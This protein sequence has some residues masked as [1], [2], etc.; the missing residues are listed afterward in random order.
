MECLEQKYSLQNCLSKIQYIF[1]VLFILCIPFQDC[2]LQGTFLRYFGMNLSNIP[3]IGLIA[4]SI[5]KFLLGEKINKKRFIFYNCLLTYIIGYS[6]IL[7]ILYT[8]G[9]FKDIYIYKIFSNSIILVFWLFAYIYTK[10]YVNSIYKYIVIANLIHIV[11]WILYDILKIDL[12]HMI[13]Y[14]NGIDYSRFHGFTFESSYFC[15]TAVILGV[16]SIFYVKNKIAKIIFGLLIL[17]FV[18]F[19]GSKGTLSCICISLFF[20]II[21]SKKYKYKVKL[22][23]FVGLAL[24]SFLGIYYVLWEA[25]LLDLEESTSFASRFSSI[26]SIIY[27][28]KEYPLGTGFGIFIPIFQSAITEAFDLLNGYIPEIIL[29][30]SEINNWLTNENGEGSVI[31]SIVIQFTAYLGIPFILWFIYYVKYTIK[32]IIL[33]DEYLWLF[34]FI[35]CG[36]VTYAGF[37]YD[38]IIGLA[39]INNKVTEI[40][41]NRYE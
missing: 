18:I 8:S 39:I 25:F 12:G 28:L 3:L 34:I 14:V 27:I 41:K 19:G 16:I 36:L 10:K 40:I 9:S 29:S 4:I 38:S 11:G 20:Y 35:L 23:L 13:H 31:R 17:I 22:I 32:N 15:F 30:Y 6:L 5:F 26:L 21:L 37:N 24:M 1:F 7:L 2:G 33:C